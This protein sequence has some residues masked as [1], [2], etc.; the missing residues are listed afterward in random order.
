MVT[1]IDLEALCIAMSTIVASV[2]Y[3]VR[4]DLVNELVALVEVLLW[5]NI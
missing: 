1:L 5:H 2:V 4:C 3:L